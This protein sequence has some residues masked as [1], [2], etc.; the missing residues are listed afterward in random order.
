MAY[1]Y[2]LLASIFWGG[3]FAAT[4]YALSHEGIGVFALLAVRYVLAAAILLAVIVI[5]TWTRRGRV[6]SGSA[7]KATRR[8][9]A[10]EGVRREDRLRFLGVS[11][12][13]PATYM[14]FETWGLDLST[15]VVGVIVIASIPALTIALARFTLGERLSAVGWVGVALSMAG[16]IAVSVL[17]P[18]STPA[19]ALRVAEDGGRPVLG[20][21]L[22]S[23]A[24]VLGAVY[25]VSARKLMLTYRPIT[26]TLVQ[27]VFGALFFLPLAAVET[28]REGL[29]S[30]GPMGILALVYLAVFAAVIA[31]LCFNH[32]IKDLGASRSSLYLNLIP[33][34]GVVG[35]WLI[36]DERLSPWQAVGG[37]LV[38]GGVLLA[39]WKGRPKA[40]APCA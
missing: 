32:A 9:R 17:A 5:R 22:L 31:F 12:I 40:V 21:L 24:A 38:I 16:V 39:S 10:W 6:A 37:V 36:L 28:A 2:L 8:G 19:D 34:F 20:A 30:P 13:Y 3:S 35:A 18:E 29:P 14:I 7:G 15:A 1:L 23:V 33:V 25:V 11:L 4:R 26:L 27:D